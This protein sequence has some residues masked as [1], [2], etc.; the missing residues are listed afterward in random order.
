MHKSNIHL[1]KRFSVAFLLSVQCAVAQTVEVTQ[2]DQ[3]LGGKKLVGFATALEAPKDEVSPAIARYLKVYGKPKQQETH[4]QLAETTLNGQVFTKPLYALVAPTTTG[5]TV[6]LGVSRTEWGADTSKILSQLELI[7]K[8]MGV[9]FYR[10]KIQ[11]QIDEAQQAVQAV[12]RQ[13]QRTVNDEQNILQ[14]TENNKREHRN[15]KMAIQRNRADSVTLY[16]K[17]QQNKRSGDSLRMV[18]DKVRK[19]LLFQQER[20]RKVN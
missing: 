12:E 13:Q 7:T 10:D 9:A 19:A 3:Q 14:R 11:A 6:W 17:L 8:S 2:Q 18:S 1:L 20:Q 16:L 15:L 4:L 5:S